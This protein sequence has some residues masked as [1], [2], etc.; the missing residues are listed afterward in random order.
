MLAALGIWLNSSLFVF[1]WAA[2][3]MW[4][5]M[6]DRVCVALVLLMNRVGGWE[7]TRLNVAK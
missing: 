6:G 7:W 3:I 4:D 1:L 2:C 5:G